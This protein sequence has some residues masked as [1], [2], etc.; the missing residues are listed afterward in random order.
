MLPM[1]D[2]SYMKV[3]DIT[4]INGN[5]KDLIQRKFSFLPASNIPDALFIQRDK[6][7]IIYITSHNLFEPLTSSSA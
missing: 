2:L 3:K 4:M 7:M 1:E 6:S 5:Q